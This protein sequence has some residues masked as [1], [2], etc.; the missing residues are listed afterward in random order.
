[1]IQINCDFLRNLTKDIA[2]IDIEKLFLKIIFQTNYKMIRSK[3]GTEYKK[4]D[5]VKMDEAIHQT[6][7]NMYM[8]QKCTDCQASPANWA[9]LKRG[10]I[11]VY[12]L[13]T[14]TSC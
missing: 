13:C 4:E 5:I 2:N 9:T 7:K 8:G 3:L 6:L 12:R 11:C 10:S 1:M 14:N